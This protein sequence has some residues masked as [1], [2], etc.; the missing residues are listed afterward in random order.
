MRQRALITRRPAARPAWFRP[1]GA[2]FLRLRFLYPAP[3]QANK[4]SGDWPSPL[5]H[6]EIVS[7][8]PSASRLAARYMMKRAPKPYDRSLLLSSREMCNLDQEAGSH[9]TDP[10]TSRSLPSLARGVGA[11]ATG[12]PGGGVKS[13]QSSG[14][15]RAGQITCGGGAPYPTPTPCHLSLPPLAPSPYPERKDLSPRV[16]IRRTCG[17]SL[18]P[19][20]ASHVCAFRQPI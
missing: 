12:Q 1:C 15:G 3:P 4:I 2:V 13:E 19:K 18:H 11:R 7:L 17:H 14:A 6:P 10:S 20:D 9:S 16:R 8:T 5:F